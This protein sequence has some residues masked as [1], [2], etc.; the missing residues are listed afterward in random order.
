M[1]QK[2]KQL[3]YKNLVTSSYPGSKKTVE[4]YTE[5]Y[6]ENL[7][8]PQEYTISQ[9]INICD[10][11]IKIFQTYRN[12]DKPT[13]NVSCLKNPLGNVFHPMKKEES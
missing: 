9:T 4:N 13:S 1:F 3:T 6:E 11:R 8:P 2:E 12:L 5:Y 7:F 10:D